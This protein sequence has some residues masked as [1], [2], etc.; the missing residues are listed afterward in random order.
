MDL[1]IKKGPECWNE[2]S[3]EEHADQQTEKED[4]NKQALPLSVY[5]DVG[6]IGCNGCSGNSCTAFISRTVIRPK[7]QVGKAVGE[8]IEE[9]PGFEQARPD[10]FG[11]A[12]VIEF[13]RDVA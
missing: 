13:R 9:V 8:R 5:V 3:L 10:G 2:E 6:Q 7:G 11:E 1:R 4:A 12:D